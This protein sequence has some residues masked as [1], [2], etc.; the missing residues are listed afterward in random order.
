[1]EMKNKKFEEGTVIKGKDL[2]GY[3]LGGVLRMKMPVT[4]NQDQYKVDESVELIVKKAKFQFYLIQDICNHLTG[5]VR[6]AIVEIPVDEDVYVDKM[7][8]H[9]DKVK[10]KEIMSL[11][12]F[13]TWKYLVERGADITASDNFPLR[14]AASFGNIEVIKY[15][16]ENG[17]DLT[18]R[19]VLNMAAQEGY[20]EVVKYLHRQGINV[21]AEDKFAVITASYYGQL[22]IV[23]YLYEH[24]ADIT[25]HDNFAVVM[26]A[27]NGYLEIVKYLHENG[28]DITVD[29]NIAYMWAIES[30]HKKV[31]NYLRKNGAGKN[32]LVD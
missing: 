19:H 21:T 2:Q 31:A 27:K 23:K 5:L 24:G 30:K 20:L 22:E 15:L 10:I 9:A 3:T 26:A 32:D 29:H 13:S 28:A 18:C 17:A 7:G 6:I 4:E 8:F 25:A 11:N 14:Y 1:M 12:D 16:A